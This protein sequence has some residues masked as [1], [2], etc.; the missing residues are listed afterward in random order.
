MLTVLMATH[1]GSDTLNRTLAAMAELICPPGGW[2]LVIVNNACTDNSDEVI[3]K[4][5]DL[6]PLDFLVEPKLGKNTALN[7]GMARVEGDFVI[8]TDDDVLPDRD[9]LVEWRRAA[10]THPQYTMFGGAIEAEFEVPPP[11]WL[12]ES[13]LAMLYAVT[14]AAH[15]EGVMKPADIFGPNM[16]VCRSVIDG[17]ARFDEQLLV[18]SE[19]LMASETEFLDRLAAQGHRACFVP[20]ARVRHI[21]QKEQVSWMWMLRRFYRGGRTTFVLHQRERRNPEPQIFHVPR[22]ALRRFAESLL[23]LP[24]VA[25][26]FDESRLFSH[27]RTMAYDLGTISQARKLARSN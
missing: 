15:I 14:D 25:L 5:K 6:L 4:W 7:A 16:A 11:R 12:E 27:L 1:N 10:D 3:L 21:V 22:C 18:G 8:M 23:R 17:G 24:L 20:R 13:W 26:T 19:G 2:K 9:W